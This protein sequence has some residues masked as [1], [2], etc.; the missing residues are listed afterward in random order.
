MNLSLAGVMS[1][2]LGNSLLKSARYGRPL[3]QFSVIGDD[4][5]ISTFGCENVTTVRV[6]SFLKSESSILLK[7]FLCQLESFIATDE[8]GDTILT[9]YKFK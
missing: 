9:L 2:E 1:I 4:I 3:F 8:S 6:H 5:R 7:I